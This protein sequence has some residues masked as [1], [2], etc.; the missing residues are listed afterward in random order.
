MITTVIVPGT[1]AEASQ[2]MRE[3]NIPREECYVVMGEHQLSWNVPGVNFDAVNELH[4]VGT[5]DTSNS[6]YP[7]FKEKEA[8]RMKPSLG[9]AVFFQKVEPIRIHDSLLDKVAE[10]NTQ[11]AKIRTA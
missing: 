2:F 10:R 7:F 9:D 5:C 11:N 3:N 8:T 1:Y 4:L 6:A